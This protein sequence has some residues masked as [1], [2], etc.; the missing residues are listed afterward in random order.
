MAI[1]KDIEDVQKVIPCHS[2]FSF[3]Q[4]EPYIPDVERQYILP[5]VQKELFAILEKDKL[6]ATNK[7]LVAEINRAVVTLAFN[8]A[9]PYLNVG[10]SGSGGLVV[11]GGEFEKPASQNRTEDLKLSTLT[12]GHNR[13]DSLIEFIEE[14]NAD[15]NIDLNLVYGDTSFFVPNAKALSKYAPI[16]NNRFVFMN[17][18]PILRESEE[19]LEDLFGSTFYNEIITSYKSQTGLDDKYSSVVKYAAAYLSYL[20]FSE[21]LIE[22]GLLVDS[23][24]VTVFNNNYAETV[25][26]QLPAGPNN[27]SELKQR[28]ADKASRSVAKLVSYLNEN[29]ADFDNWKESKHYVAEADAES[30]DVNVVSEGGNV[31]M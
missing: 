30:S 25:S 3:D 20:S 5:I 12:D 28:Y 13:L 7:R 16:R 29:V 6:S 8:K 19:G 24:G 21:A 17:M 2:D 18:V 9:I 31:V 27:V 26:V 11:G 14:N 1:V 23:R 4:L 22:I 10:I 15:Y